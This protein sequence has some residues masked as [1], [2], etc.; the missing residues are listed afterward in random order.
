MA[1]QAKM[2]TLKRRDSR[3]IQLWRQHQRAAELCYCCVICR[4]SDVTAD[5]PADVQQA[6]SIWFAARM[7]SGC[8]VITLCRYQYLLNAV[9]LVQ[10]SRPSLM[11]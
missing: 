4:W 2:S 11:I 6:R 3:L 7:V 1:A 9:K 8:P 5:M 10:K